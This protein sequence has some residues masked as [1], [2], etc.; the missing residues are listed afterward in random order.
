MKERFIAKFSLYR[1]NAYFYLNLKIIY[2]KKIYF[3]AMFAA[4]VLFSATVLAQNITSEQI[5]PVLEKL[6]TLG[7]QDPAGL[8]PLHKLSAADQQLFVAYERQIN[9]GNN[10]SAT[11][12][13]KLITNAFVHDGRNSRYGK[14][15]LV[16]PPVFTLLQA[17]Q[18]GNFYCDDIAADG[19]VYAVNS[20]DF[21]L[22]KI[23]S[24]GTKTKIGALTNTTAGDT[25]TALSWNPVTST[26]YMISGASSSGY[27]LYTVNLATG[28]A[29]LKMPLS[30]FTST[31]I[32]IWMDIDNSGN[33]YVA[34]VVNDNLWKLNLDSGAATMI[35]SLGINIQ[36][37]QDA[38]FNRETNVLYMAAYFGAAVGQG[39]L[40]TVNTTTGAT[41]LVGTN[42]S[43]DGL[44]NEYT[45]FSITDTIP[46]LGVSSVEKQ[47]IK[48]YPNPATDVVKLA[49]DKKIEQVELLNMEG[50]VILTQNPERTAAEI[51]INKLPAG[52]YIL[53]TKIDGKENSTKI[54]KK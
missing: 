7:K 36:F 1:L 46:A 9:S 3:K 18:T 49:A 34:E 10:H 44:T 6:E 52:N 33:A 39:Q 54:I 40:R 20:A 11:A 17:S 8:F 42:P 21:S 19:N 28:V 15:D 2:M 23:N 27:K 30:G 41:T 26:M 53:K 14:I 25:V 48:V 38:D 29:T 37:A 35:G 13:N 51:N 32:P 50:R 12:P 22:Y 31:E 43:P 45:M 47:K 5:R 16:D 24:D 4:A